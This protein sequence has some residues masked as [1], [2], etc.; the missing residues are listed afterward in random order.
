MHLINVNK[1]V[2]D[3]NEHIAEHN[4]ELFDDHNVFVLNIMSAPGAGKTTFL[5]ALL[6][7]LSQKYRVGVIEGDMF[8]S[9][10]ADRLQKCCNIPVHQINTH[11]IC[12]LDAKMIHSS[13]DNFDLHNLDLLI[14]ENVGNLVCP[15]EFNLGEDKR[16]M[17]LSVTEGDDKPG[18]YPVMFRTADAIVLNK[19]DLLP[20]S[21]FNMDNFV[22][23]VRQVNGRAGI[24]EISAFN[25]TGL[26]SVLKFITDAI[27]SKK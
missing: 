22:K 14:V 8:G 23:R 5:E 1:N 21:N 13:L 26:D 24:F 6:P 9:L 11:N 18:K 16:L 4:K 2:M 3:D 19:I 20:Y 27:D 10:D 7:L 12:H 15:A 17:L 25:R